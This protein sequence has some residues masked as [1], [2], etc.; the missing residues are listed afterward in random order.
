[1]KERVDMNTEN[2]G[3]LY[4]LARA[5]CFMKISTKEMN[6]RLVGLEIN[7][8]SPDSENNFIYLQKHLSKEDYLFFISNID[9][10]YLYI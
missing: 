5:Y 10:D 9:P 7:K 2:T 3:T 1:M 6:K 4:D 8:D